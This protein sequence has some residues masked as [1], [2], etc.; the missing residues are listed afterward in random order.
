MYYEVIHHMIFY[1]AGV[2][3]VQFFFLYSTDSLGPILCQVPGL[4]ILTPQRILSGYRA[5][6]FFRRPPRSF[7]LSYIVRQY[8]YLLPGFWELGA[9]GCGRH[10]WGNAQPTRPVYS[11]TA[12]VEVGVFNSFPS[13]YV[14]CVTYL[15]NNYGVMATHKFY[16]PYVVYILTS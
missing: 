3:E 15:R 13:C 7:F 8:L 2:P 5:F 16:V 10:L 6:L 14:D 11:S 12:P 4:R 9:C 1:F